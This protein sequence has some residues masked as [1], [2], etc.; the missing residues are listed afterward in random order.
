V[1]VVCQQRKGIKVTDFSEPRVV[2]LGPVALAKDQDY[3][4]F[5]YALLLTIGT[6]VGLWWIYSNGVFAE[7]IYKKLG[8]FITAGFVLILVLGLV[9]GLVESLAISRNLNALKRQRLNAKELRAYFGVESFD[10]KDYRLLE[11]VIELRLFRAVEQVQNYA[12][13]SAYLG[14]FG[15][16]LGLASSLGV[17]SEVRSM[18]DMLQ[19]LPEIGG[20]LSVAFIATLTGIVITVL[21]QQMFR[22]VR[23]GAQ[24]LKIRVLRSLHNAQ[25]GDDGS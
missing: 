7:Q 14:L 4:Q 2:N 21:L 25:K 10:T 20:H 5:L 9:G 19:K 12:K 24:D 22:L 11:E 1:N 15:T 8:P 13:L 3:R 23:A 17:L 16:A 18:E 6:S